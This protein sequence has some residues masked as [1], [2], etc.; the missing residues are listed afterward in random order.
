[1]TFDVFDDSVCVHACMCA[2][3]CMW[4]REWTR[5]YVSMSVSFLLLSVGCVGQSM[6]YSVGGV[7][8]CLPLGGA[9]QV[10]QW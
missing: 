3:M 6:F 10:V 7:S 9:S 4:C 5:V 2:C 1:M 8:I